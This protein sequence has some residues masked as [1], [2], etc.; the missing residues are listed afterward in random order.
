MA[1]CMRAGELM[2][3]PLE[4]PTARAHAVARSAKPILTVTGGNAFYGQRQVLHDVTLELQPGECVALVGESGSGKT[5]LARGIIG[6]HA[7]SSGEIRFKGQPLSTSARKR[8]ADVRRRVQYVFQSPYNSLNPRRTV[9]QSVGLP[10]AEF[11]SLKRKA[12]R[13]S[14]EQALEHVSL[15]AHLTSR[16]PHE[17]S[18]GERQRVAIARALIC[19]PEVL[20]CDEVTSSL[21]VSVQA[22]IV[23]LLER[24][25]SEDAL[26]MLFVTHNLALV[27]SIAD[28]VVVIHNGRLVEQGPTSA[29]LGAPQQEYTRQL[30][31]DTPSLTDTPASA[32]GERKLAVGITTS[33]IH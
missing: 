31:A 25:R 11:L 3:K 7:I 32:G 23:Q 9:E 16:Y 30:L 19:K 29:I 2:G 21:D 17:L 6:L 8:S 4:L 33:R 12:L 10:A 27:M 24:L 18:G 22:S 20:I 28:R 1:R 15:P 26:A 5:T 14:V 13:A